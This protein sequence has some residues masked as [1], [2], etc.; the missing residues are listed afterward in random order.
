MTH[1]H[2]TPV[3]SRALLAAIPQLLILAATT[4]TAQEVTPRRWSHLPANKNF[5]GGAIAYT[6]GDIL[7][8]PV[9]QV[10]DGTVNLTTYAL[11][12][13][14]SFEMLGKSSR[15]DLKGGHQEGNWE[16]LLEGEPASTSRSGFSDPS[17]RLAVNLY[18]APPLEG[19]AFREYRATASTETIVGLGLNVTLPLGQYDEE[20]LI[21]LGGNRYTIRPQLGVVHTRG[22]WT[23]EITGSV[24]FF[25]DNDEYWNGNTLEQEPMLAG[26]AHLIYTLRPG[27]W[28][29]GSGAY[30]YGAEVSVNGEEK[31]SLTENL[32]YAVNAGIPIT[33]RLGIKCSWVGARTQFRLGSDTDTLSAALSYMW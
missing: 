22:K 4:L 12:Y 16:G 2:R 11:S 7:F 8:D 18:G 30:G 17:I 27:L 14:R 10:E 3:I 24:W 9:L 21:N 6:T 29:S 13:I 28:L 19:K 1:T 32:L 15:I 23:G 33:P 26:Q 25:T 5:G 31:E 20:R